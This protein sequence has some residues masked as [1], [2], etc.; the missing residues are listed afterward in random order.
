MKIEMTDTSVTNIIEKILLLKDKYITI[1]TNLTLQEINFILNSVE[2]IFKT[3]SCLL[4]LH[5]P[6][7][8]V[9]DIHGQLHDL[10]RI[11]DKCGYPPSTRYLFLGDYVDRG[12]RSIETVI[13]LFCYKILYPD[14]IFLLR[15]NH[16]FQHVNA[17]CGFRAEIRKYYASPGHGLWKHFNNVFDFLSISALI[18]N[19]I[20]CVHGGISPHLTSFQ[21]ISDIQK[22]LVSDSIYDIESSEIVIDFLWSEVDR[23]IDGFEIRREREDVFFGLNALEEFVSKFSLKMIC[24]GHEMA[25]DGVEFPFWPN[26]AF[27][28]IFSAPKFKFRH[29]NKAA[30]VHFD[31]NLEFKV[32]TFEPIDPYVE[33]A[34]ANKIKEM[35]KK[36]KKKNIKNI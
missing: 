22:P 4:E 27:L 31:E 35:M 33:P 24:R 2:T 18:N 1:S 9:G 19:Q 21:E 7:T 6:I 5:P 28:T 25:M 3:E 34:M 13:L 11:F 10:L 12:F 30:V 15:G 14:Q 29:D 36:K 23:R 16:E 32:S 8:L 17:Y 26:E 20:F